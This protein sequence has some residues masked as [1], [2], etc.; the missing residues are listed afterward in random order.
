ML[1]KEQR[2]E[3]AIE[4]MKKL[5]IYEPYIE[6]YKEHDH[7]CFYERFGGYWVNQDPEIE[8][9]MRE[10]EQQYNVTIYAITHEPTEFGD[11][12]SFLCVAN[13]GS[14]YACTKSFGSF[15]SDFICSAY[16][17]NKSGGFVEGGSVEVRSFGGGLMRIG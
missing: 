16:V 12:W 6:G 14:R 4:I 13:K 1:T 5:G 10:I 15:C 9:K 11:L 3:K 2:K 8:A 17:W 7:V